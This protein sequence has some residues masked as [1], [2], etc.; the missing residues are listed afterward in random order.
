MKIGTIPNSALH[1]AMR[2]SLK[3]SYTKSQ[4]L[5]WTIKETVETKVV[6]TLHPANTR[7]RDKLQFHENL[8]QIKPIVVLNRHYFEKK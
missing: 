2:K 5:A 7:F 6:S 8:L 4:G 1:L 3:K